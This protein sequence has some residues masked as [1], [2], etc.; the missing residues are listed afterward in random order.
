MGPKIMA[1]GASGTL[2]LAR[3]SDLSRWPARAS[4][5][6]RQLRGSGVGSE[7]LG[8]ESGDL[9]F[10]AARVSDLSKDLKKMTKS[11]VSDLK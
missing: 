6:R 1:S 9:R 2:S 11:R 5:L 7:T 3:V 8:T 10:F 4:D